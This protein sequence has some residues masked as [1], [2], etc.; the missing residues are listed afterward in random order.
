MP[1]E[2]LER[3]AYLAATPAA[4]TFA[5]AVSFPAGTAP[6]AIAAADF[7]GDGHMDLAVA[8]ATAEDG[9]HLLRGTATGTTFTAG[10]GA[11]S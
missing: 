10:P 9:Q 8:D 4:V 7:N 1:I 5:P 3:R 2:P 6:V 11:A